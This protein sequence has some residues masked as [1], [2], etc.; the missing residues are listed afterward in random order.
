[1]FGS[2][3]AIAVNFVVVRV[4]TTRASFGMIRGVSDGGAS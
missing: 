2:A 3:A 4:T 1:M